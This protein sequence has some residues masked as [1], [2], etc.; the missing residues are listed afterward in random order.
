[1]DDFININLGILENSKALQILNKDDL[2]VSYDFN[3]LYPSA[4][5]D[6]DITWPAIETLYSDKK[7]YDW[8]SLWI[9]W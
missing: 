9:F 5:V 3:R 2:L 6:E 8:C 7:I 4:E 1:M